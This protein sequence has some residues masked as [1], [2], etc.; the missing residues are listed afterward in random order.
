MTSLPTCL[1][2]RAAICVSIITPAKK[3]GATACRFPN[4]ILI[5]GADSASRVLYNYYGGRAAFPRVS[6]R[7]IAEVDKA[8]SANSPVKRSSIRRDGCCLSFLMDPRTGLGRFR[9]FRISNYELMMQLVDYC[10]EHTIEQIL[11][12]PDVRERIELYREHSDKFT[13]QI[14]RCTRM[15]GSV[16]VL[17]LRGEEA[18]YAGNRS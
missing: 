11:D 14:R 6:E 5:S 2:C 8:D 15:H 7:M 1:T 10:R 4:H 18:I 16:A 12:L 17:D 9:E 3:S 13:A